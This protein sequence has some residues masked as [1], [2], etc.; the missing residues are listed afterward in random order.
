MSWYDCL[1]CRYSLKSYDVFAI[2]HPEVA[3]CK[4]GSWQKGGDWL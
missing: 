2:G 4:G 1:D 3:K